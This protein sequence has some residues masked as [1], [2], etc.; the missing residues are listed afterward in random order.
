M[1]CTMLIGRC[2][3]VFVDYLI[4]IKMSL[5]LFRHVIDDNRI[6]L[7]LTDGS[8]AFEIKDFLVQQDRCKDVTIDNRVYPGQGTQVNNKTLLVVFHI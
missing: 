8:Q 5:F 6:L 2:R 4:C 7:V 3:L 1:H